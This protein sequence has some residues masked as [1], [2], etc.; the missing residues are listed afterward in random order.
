MEHIEKVIIPNILE[1]IK[2]NLP[3]NNLLILTNDK[4]ENF[5]IDGYIYLLAIQKILVKRPNYFNS[6]LS[7]LDVSSYKIPVT[8]I[9]KE[10]EEAPK[11]ISLI[12]STF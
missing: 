1:R 3:L 6:T 5:L 11:I 9:F 10:I 4:H 12:H 8:I 7:F 2:M